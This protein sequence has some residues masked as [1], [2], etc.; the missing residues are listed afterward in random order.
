MAE[1]PETEHRTPELTGSPCLQGERVSFTG[2]LASM[3]HWQ[4]HQ[5]AEQ[6]GGAATAHLSRQT[7]M[8]VVGEEG[9]PLDPDG[10]PSQKLRQ[11]VEWQ[12]QGAAIRILNES[13]W[14]H[15]LGLD[16][17]RRE[18]HRQYTPA[19]L[20]GLLGV[21]VGVIRGWERTG[22][23][24]PVRT[25]YR[26][27]Y[28]DFQEV[29]GARRIAELLAAGV[30]PREIK[31]SLHRLR[32]VLTG[33]DRPLAQLDLLAQNA[34]L[35]YRDDRGLV[36]PVSGQR[37]FDF[38][39]SN[40]D[41]NRETE[42]GRAGPFRGDTP[43]LCGDTP[44]LCSPLATHHSPLTPSDLRA[45]WAA[46]DWFREGCRLLE[47]NE[48]RSAV[49]ALRLALMDRPGDAEIN[50]H[51]AEAL[52][53]LGNLAGALERYYAAVESDHNY[54]ESWTQLGCLHAEQG[55]FDPALE[56]FEIALSI[57]ADYP[58]A[59]W[60]KASVLHQLGRTDEAV[61]HWRSYLR[62]D[63]RGPWAETARQR[64]EEATAE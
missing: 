60:Q 31:S 59:H 63:T 4:A 32:S 7:T 52:Y 20:S 17:R 13:E 24:T 54:I 12:Q 27:P 16:E 48:A 38:D 55:Q 64:L 14:L 5:L 51:L 11:A 56:A 49:E 43:R 42:P 39:E 46:D 41:S 21:P 3:P 29:A 30:S 50:F 18:V 45:G 58:D 1:R 34:R 53:R 10:R 62:H 22:L 2:T 26:L 25:V 44:Q 47:A 28:F 8:L 33:I 19:M 9:W 35:L 15:L 6:H 57:H 61:P 36:E 23:I 37:C 40:E